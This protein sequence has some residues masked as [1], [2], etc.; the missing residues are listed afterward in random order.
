MSDRFE[1]IPR[2][3]EPMRVPEPVQGEPGLFVV[4]GS[5]GAIRPIELDPGLRTVGELEVIAH[6]EQGGAAVDC[7]QPE[8]YA[9]GTIGDAINIPHPETL[10]RIDELD[11]TRASVFF[12]N[13]P[14]CAATPHAI[15]LL[16]EA[17]FPA[18]SILYYRGGLHDWITL[19]LPL[20]MTAE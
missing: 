18:S 20:S 6:L 10:S 1:R 14:Q 11:R 5:W 13:G 12:C 19:G 2:R 9:R 16:L 4:D 7:R 8:V 3:D 17:G 15:E